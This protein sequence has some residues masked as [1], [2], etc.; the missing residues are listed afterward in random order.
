MKLFEHCETKFGQ[1]Q[2]ENYIYFEFLNLF[3][4]NKNFSKT[5]NAPV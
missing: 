2:N 5:S 3:W 4:K 1:L